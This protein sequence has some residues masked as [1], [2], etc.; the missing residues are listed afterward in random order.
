MKNIKLRT[1][2]Y[3]FETHPQGCSVKRQLQ[4]YCVINI[5]AQI[6]DIQQYDVGIQAF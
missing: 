2:V 1:L 6:A 3:E 4:L 5:N